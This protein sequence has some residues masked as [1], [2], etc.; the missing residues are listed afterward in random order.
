MCVFI[1]SVGCRASIASSNTR[2][3]FAVQGG[4]KQD[5]INK[6]QI[7]AADMDLKA[8]VSVPLWNSVHLMK[9][10]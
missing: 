4:G 5:Q 6:L 1:D 3:C 2:G 7:L 9:P 10:A 8:S